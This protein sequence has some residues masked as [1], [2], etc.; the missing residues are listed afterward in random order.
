[1]ES[2]ATRRSIAAIFIY[3]YVTLHARSRPSPCRRASASSAPTAPPARC[4]C[5]LFVRG[6]V[7]MV[8]GGC[9]L[10][11]RI[12]FCIRTARIGGERGR[13]R[14]I[15]ECKT[16]ARLSRLTAG[17]GRGEERPYR[18]PPGLCC[19]PHVCPC[20]WPLLMRVG[21]DL[22]LERRH[23]HAAPPY[24]QAEDR[25]RRQG[26]QQ[27]AA[28]TAAAD[29]SPHCPVDACGW[30]GVG[31]ECVL[32]VCVHDDGSI[33]VPSDV[34]DHVVWIEDRRPPMM[35]KGTTMWI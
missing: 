24:D 8:A 9:D 17:E 21:R 31:G 23:Q 13:H 26:Q 29:E 1:M 16:E 22:Q 7:R 32:N 11:G 28:A 34:S 6:W 10:S 12:F 3:V 35:K 14:R 15:D 19:R 27:D 18:P 20:R 25:R 5:P 2:R 33:R 30:S 4:Q